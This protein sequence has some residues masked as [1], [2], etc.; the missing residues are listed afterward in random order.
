MKDYYSLLGVRRFASDA[1]IKR[2]YRRLALKYHPDKNPDPG[3]ET[4]I[5]ELNEAYDLLSDPSQ[6]SWYDQMLVGPVYSTPNHEQPPV[7]RQA[8]HRDPAYRGTGKHRRPYVS[9]RERLFQLVT[10]YHPKM[11][12]ISKISF[13]LSV[14]FFLDYYIPYSEKEEYVE[15]RHESVSRHGHSDYFLY[16]YSGER[17]KIYDTKIQIKDN[18][19]LLVSYTR[20]YGIPMRVEN[21]MNSEQANLA[22]MYNTLL[23]LP[24]LL[25]IV[26]GLAIYQKDDIE[27]SFNLIVLNGMLLLIN[28]VFV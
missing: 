10:H 13:V 24:V 26:S 27:F 3:A 2:A 28:F 9:K 17:F 25:L 8:A 1:E 18:D 22:Y 15:Y 5:K 20:I 16:L 23:F 21:Q 6:R 19:Q 11:L 7:E 4:I 12:W 14:L